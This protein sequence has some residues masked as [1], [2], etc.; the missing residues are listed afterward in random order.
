[1]YFEWEMHR[2]PR[3]G[4]GLPH[5][6]C[7]FLHPLC[8]PSLNELLTL[9]SPPTPAPMPRKPRLPLSSV[10]AHGLVTPGQQIVQVFVDGAP[11]LTEG[12]LGSVWA[13]G[14]FQ[15]DLKFFNTAQQLYEAVTGSRSPQ[16]SRQI[17]ISG[18]RLNDLYAAAR[19]K[20]PSSKAPPPLPPGPPAAFTFE[21]WKAL[22][23]GQLRDRFSFNL[24]GL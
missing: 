8:S 11:Q 9:S 3:W 16:P 21:A 17:E 15:W 22:L 14:R 13:S 4:N 19:K 18:C 6:W 12:Q 5:D 20:G 1:M 7:L 10:I 2:R 24:R 23:T